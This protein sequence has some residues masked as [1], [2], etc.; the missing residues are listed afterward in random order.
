MVDP[1]L[2]EITFKADILYPLLYTNSSYFIFGHLFF[3]AGKKAT[4][5]LILSSLQC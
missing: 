1:V 5:L 3:P 4:V 2:L